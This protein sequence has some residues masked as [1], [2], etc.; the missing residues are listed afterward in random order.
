MNISAIRFPIRARLICNIELN[1]RYIPA[2]S[3]F[4][5]RQFG[6]LKE[7]ALGNADSFVSVTPRVGKVE[8]VTIPEISFDDPPMAD[9]L[10]VR[11]CDHVNFVIELRQS[12]RIV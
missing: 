5:R 9:Q 4:V 1:L 10:A 7:V 3:W 11:W 6:T 12:Y 2:H 8:I